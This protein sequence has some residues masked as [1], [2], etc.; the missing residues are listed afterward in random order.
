MKVLDNGISIFRDDENQPTIEGPK[1]LKKSGYY[2]ILAPAGGVPTGWQT[3]LRSKNLYGPYEAKIVLHQGETAINGPHQGGLVELESGESWFLHFQDLDPYGRIVHLQPV[4]WIDDWPLM[5]ID[6]NGDGIG[7][8]VLEYRKP[9]VGGEY[10]AVIPQTSDEFNDEAL[11]LQWQWHANPQPEWYSIEGGKLQLNA[12]QNLSQQGDFWFVPNLLLQ[13]FPAPAFSASTKIQFEPERIGEQ[14]GL[15]VMGG[16]WA[17]IA[18]E[19]TE[20][21]L[22]IVW[23]EGK[24]NRCDPG[25]ILIREET[26]EANSCYLRVSVEEGGICRFSYST[27]SSNYFEYDRAF[28]AQPGKWIGAKVGLFCNNPNMDK[29]KGYALFSHFT[30]E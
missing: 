1:F 6:Q 13:K 3:V 27:D 5:G 14:A 10:Q 29:S 12:V 18:M 4:Q 21:G 11:G 25:T 20:K 23:Y 17:Y 24:Y 9:H 15:L 2:Y 16:E 26:I 19:K 28:M 22:K 8:P 30:L 7:E